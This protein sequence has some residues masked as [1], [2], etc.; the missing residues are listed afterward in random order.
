IHNYNLSVSGGTDNI[1]YYVSGTVMDENGVLINTG[2]STYSAR[3]NV[4][5]KVNSFISTG[6]TLSPTYSKR[7]TSP[8]SMEAIVKTAPF[9]SPIRN[10]NG[11]YPR[12]RDYWGTSVSAQVSPLATLEET[13]NYSSAMNNIGE[14]YLG[15]KIL[16]GLDFR[17]TLGTNLTYVNGS[18]F[19]G[20]AAVSNGLNSGS[21]EDSKNITLV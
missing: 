21:A 8:V 17:S 18:K 12:P 6:F 2:Y 5:L 4:D 9:V 19:Q 10:P 1:K 11:T 13:Y 14:M 16:E 3:A 7:R 20:A 15:V